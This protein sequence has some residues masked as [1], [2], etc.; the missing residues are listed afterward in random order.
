MTASDLPTLNASLNA[1]A[2]V[3]LATGYYFIRTGRRE[4][5]RACMIAALVASALFLTSYVI[6][7]IQV[8]SVPFKGV[9]AIRTVY[10][11]ILITHVVLAIVIVPLVLMT[12]SRALR[13]RFDRHR[14]I[15]RWTLPLWL[16]VSVTGV[17]V[18][19]MLYRMQP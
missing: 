6:Y 17:I 2:A 18:Y 13:G 8:G 5:H 10:F 3:L 11:T 4:R 19:W 14:A 9:G 1:T 15:A 16:Y 12:V 7:H